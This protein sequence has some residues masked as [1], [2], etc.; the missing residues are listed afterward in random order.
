MIDRSQWR[1]PGDPNQR[2]NPL[3][4]RWRD[5]EYQTLDTL[6]WE[7]RTSMSALVR[8]LVLEAL[9]RA[10]IKIKDGADRPRRTM[11]ESTN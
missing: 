1:D 6:A 8:S 2:R 5:A 3:S 7:R 4:V 10:G 9:E 11:P